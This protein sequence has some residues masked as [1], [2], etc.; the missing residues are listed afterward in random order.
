MSKALCPAGCGQK[1][2]SKEHAEV[3]ADKEHPD[4]RVPK[5][6][7]WATPYGFVD[8]SYQVTYDHACKV[9]KNLYEDNK[10]KAGAL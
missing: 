9:A 8:F 7:S 2:I 3:H 4:W 10:T 1:Y 5:S 6:R